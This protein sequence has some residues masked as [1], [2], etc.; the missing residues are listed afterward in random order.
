MNKRDT[1]TNWTDPDD[2]PELTD[3]FF[4]QADEFVGDRLVRRCRPKA[5]TTKQP[6]TVRYDHD[7]VQAFKA[8]DK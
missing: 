2:A 3:E 5:G 1:D 7:I 6:L 4:K 8:T